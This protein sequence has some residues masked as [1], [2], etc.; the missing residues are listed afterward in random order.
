MTTIKLGIFSDTHL[1]NNETDVIRANDSFEAF[2]QS[3]RIF[4]E[5]NVDAILHAG[6]LFDIPT[7]SKS[8]LNKAIE[9]LQKYIFMDPIEEREP[10]EVEE[11]PEPGKALV[12]EPNTH[13]PNI[14]IKTPIF[15]I[16]GNHDPPVGLGSLSAC[17]LFS[18]IH[19]INYFSKLI[20]PNE[21]VLNPVI[22]HKDNIRVC[23]YGFHNI[24]EAS[25]AVALKQRQV[26]FVQ[27]DPIEGVYQYN[28]LLLHQNFRIYER[29]SSNPL[30]TSEYLSNIFRANQININ[31]VVWGHEHQ[32]KMEIEITNGVHIFQPGSTVATDIGGDFQFENRGVGVLQISF[33]QENFTYYHLDSRPCKYKV[34]ELKGNKYRTAK[35]VVSKIKETIEEMIEMSKPK[36]YP[37]IYL[38]VVSETFDLSDISDKKIMGEY[39]SLVANPMKFLKLSHRKRQSK[40]S[41]KRDD[42]ENTES[43]PVQIETL[44]ENRF[45]EDSLS[46]LNVATFNASLKSFIYSNEKNSQKIFEEN[47][48]KLKNIRVDY[49]IENAAEWGTQHEIEAIDAVTAKEYISSQKQNLPDLSIDLSSAVVTVS[50][51]AENSGEKSVK[52]R[53]RR[54]RKDQEKEDNESENN[55]L[56]VEEPVHPS[57]PRR[58]A[59][60]NEKPASEFI[61]SK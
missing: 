6:D 32:G 36:P 12:H 4:H 1:G 31:L 48:N 28:I 7:P 10:I 30:T 18:S 29:N 57:R 43:G 17:D 26:F 9:I 3:L 45:L 53:G 38:K 19:Y 15:M 51:E 33:E 27:P 5:N 52:K 2:E 8:S 55:V 35:D 21:I 47:L 13:D 11:Y 37:I 56:E 61:T 49:L 22:I 46:F 24:S 34:L 50:N 59:N 23:V 58:R 20:N 40:R 14:L 44:I 25:F 60:R 54:K 16:H 41:Q 42:Q 39:S